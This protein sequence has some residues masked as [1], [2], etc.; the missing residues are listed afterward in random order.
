MSNLMIFMVIQ[1][2]IKLLEEQL[3]EN[4]E[5]GE[6]C[7]SLHSH[8]SRNKFYSAVLFADFFITKV[9]MAYGTRFKVMDSR[10]THFL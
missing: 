10:L 7:E 6:L 2:R 3:E 8:F 9:L 1:E 5:L 4:G